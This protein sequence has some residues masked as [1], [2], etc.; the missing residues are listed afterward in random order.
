MALRAH[1]LDLL[2]QVAHAPPNAAALNFYLLLT[3][4]T[5]GPHSPSPST[6]LAVVGICADKTR[7]QVM[8]ARSLDLEPSFVGACM[9]GKDLQD[10]LGAIEHT[11]L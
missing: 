8:K 1:L 3:K 4:S 6:N 9:L 5:A 11:C 7:Q 10:E 2:L